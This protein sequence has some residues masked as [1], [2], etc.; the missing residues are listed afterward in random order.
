MS[1]AYAAD[2]GPVEGEDAL[3]YLNVFDNAWA[4]YGAF[5]ASNHEAT[6]IG[7][8]DN[9]P[10][11]FFIKGQEPPEDGAW[12]VKN[13]WGGGL[14]SGPDFGSF[15]I[16][17][18]GDGIGD[19][20]FWLSYYDAS[21]SFT[22]SFDYRVEDLARQIAAVASQREVTGIINCCSGMAIPLA[23]EAERY[24]RENNMK[25]RLDYGKFPDRADASPEVW[26][27]PTKINEILKNDR[28]CG[29]LK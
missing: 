5:G 3:V 15:G 13:S 4:Q 12:L 8:N 25:I 11:T 26:G 19:G 24:I 21:I 16:D 18:N 2:G 28:Q 10:K 22:E 1:F 14:S 20:Y 23:E 27:D 7:Y 29:C 17:E 6:I 9:F